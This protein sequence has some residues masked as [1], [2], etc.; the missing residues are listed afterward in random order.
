MGNAHFEWMYQTLDSTTQIPCEVR[1]ERVILDGKSLAI[2]FVRDLSEI[3]NA[4]SM[5]KQLE[6]AAFTDSLTGVRNRRY[7]MEAAEK[8]LQICIEKKRPYSLAMIDIDY[9]KKINDTY[10]HPVGDEVLVIVVA[11]IRHVLKSD[12]L[13]A[14]YGGEE[15]VVML[16]ALNHVNVLKTAQ[17]IRANIEASPFLI[18]D[19]EINVTISLG[20]ASRTKQ[21]TTLLE[22]IGNADKALYQAKQAG[23]NRV[24]HYDPRDEGERLQE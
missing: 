13:V 8:E 18:G 17:R 1:L 12:A 15:F 6:Q 16:P 2:A 10:G 20:T 9:F 24:V 3:N 22:I 14:R 21:S 4:V 11:R 19:M 7:F 23:R 5:A